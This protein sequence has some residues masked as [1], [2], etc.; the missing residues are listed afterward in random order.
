MHEMFDINF[1]HLKS[2]E[3]EIE[4]SQFYFRTELNL[5]NVAFNF[6]YELIQFLTMTPLTDWISSFVW[7]TIIP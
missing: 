5:M 2:K 6:R 3:F 7:K 4:N 1:E